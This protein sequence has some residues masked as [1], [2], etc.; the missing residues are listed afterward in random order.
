MSNGKSKNIST[1]AIRLLVAQSLRPVKRGE[2][3]VVLEDGRIEYR[4]GDA[5][6]AD[7]E[8]AC[9]QD[10]VVVYPYFLD[11]SRGPLGVADQ[12]TRE[13]LYQWYRR[14]C[15]AGRRSVYRMEAM[16]LFCK[17]VGR[18]FLPAKSAFARGQWAEFEQQAREGSAAF[19]DILIRSSASGMRY[20]L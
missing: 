7:E 19:G 2:Y 8:A 15:I 4:R 12:L 18:G 11:T 3:M 9:Q 13:E 16:L 5:W 14:N 6:Y 20:Y 17:A 1:R 10:G